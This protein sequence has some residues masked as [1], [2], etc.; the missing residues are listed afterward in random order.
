MTKLKALLCGSAACFAA[1]FSA[2]AADL[3]VKAKSVDYVKVCSAHG[4]GFYYIPGSDTCLKIGGEVRAEYAFVDGNALDDYQI[5]FHSRAYV[6][7]DARNA[8]EY[9]TLR[10]FARLQITVQSGAYVDAY[11]EETEIELDRAFIQYLGLTAGRTQ[12]FWDFTENTNWGTLRF[13]D[14]HVVNLLA[15]THTFGDG[16]SATLSLEDPTSRH[17]FD[18]WI[19]LDHDDRL[20]VPDVVAVLDLEREWGT[21]HLAAVAHENQQ[22]VLEWDRTGNMIYHSEWGWAIGFGAR[23][24]VDAVA[25]GDYLWLNAGYSR[26][27]LPYLL[28][29]NGIRPNL[30]V[31][32]DT[33]R[34]TSIEL[35]KGWQVS[36]GIVHNWTPTLKTSLFGSYAE[37]DPFMFHP[38][39]PAFYKYREYRVG[40]QNVWAP[41]DGFE[42]GFEVLYV[43]IDNRLIAG[44]NPRPEND[45]DGNLWEVRLRMVRQY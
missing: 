20:D 14:G 25:E 3:P 18:T 28:D 27:A 17:S 22:F 34:L 38:T 26:G 10:A 12:S 39:I 37:V 9:G 8:T 43:D 36:G 1:A 23:V 13:S 42:M 11:S 15:Y 5:G 32:T 2:E 44:M 7:A 16:F 45:A 6:E 19:G 4:E 40:L 24:N 21:L 33:N 35:M 29:D 31:H 30:F 41:A